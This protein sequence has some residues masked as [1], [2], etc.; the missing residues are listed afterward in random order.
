MTRAPVTA[1]NFMARCLNLLR[2]G[3]ARYRAKPANFRFGIMVAVLVL[4][5][6]LFAA[7][8]LKPDLSHLRITLLSGP[9]DGEDYALGALLAQEAH[10]HKS[11]LIN[12][13]TTG[14]AANLAALV[15]ASAAGDTLFALVPDGLNYPE[16]DRLALAARLPRTR[17]LF[18]LGRKADAIHDFSDLAGMRI[19]LGPP[20]SA[21]ALLGR[22]LFGSDML[23]GLDVSLSEHPF[24][25]QLERL[26]GE[27]LDLGLFVMESDAPLIEQAVRDGLPIV[28]FNNAEA[29]A[30]RMPA[31]RV[32]TLYR[33]YFDPRRPL[34]EAN[35]KVF[36]VD[37]LVLTDAAVARSQAVAML[38]LLD[39]VFK[40]FIPLNQATP[41]RTGLPE[42]A[43]L[44][45]FLADNG[46]SFLDRYA[47]R[48]LDFM[49]PANLLHYVVV[50]SLLLNGLTFWHRFRL[51]R[52]DVHRTELENLTLDLFGHHYTVKE[53]ARMSPRPGE[54]CDQE[55][56]LL[57]ELINKTQVLRQQIRHY[58]T[59]F[60]VPMGAEIYYRHQETLLAEQLCS[61]RQFR[62]R[63]QELDADARSISPSPP[64]TKGGQ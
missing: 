33:G 61:L 35:K 23:K 25:E 31:L 46:P 3:L 17:T 30:A 6:L 63:L 19:G 5:G 59:S 55:R 52:I 50:I 29:L 1:V 42:V 14:A 56:A 48:L 60:V 47:P 34:P 43:D 57:D 11:A 40:G 13:A 36:Q 9:R 4:L 51:W 24:A 54:F 37:L 38:T 62:D 45:P 10:R 58:S 27:E 53:I 41:N 39:T 8:D 7:I 22:T 20:G 28:G 18:L 32:V 16:S 15:E 49:P 2:R 21:T 44:K 64:F 12:R 26:K